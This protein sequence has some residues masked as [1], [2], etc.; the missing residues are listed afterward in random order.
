MLRLLFHGASAAVFCG[1]LWYDIH[2]IDLGAGTG[3]DVYG[4]KLRF[5]TFINLCV[6]ALFYV[7]CTLYDVAR[8]ARFSPKQLI[9]VRSLK[10]HLFTV[11]VFPVGAFVVLMFWGIYAVDRELIFPQFLDQ[12]FPAWANHVMHTVI[13]PVNLLEMALDYHTHPVP[14]WS[15]LKHLVGFSLAYQAWTLWVYFKT[16]S[17]IYPIFNALNG[18]QKV[19]FLQGATLMIILLYFVGEFLQQKVFKAKK[20]VMGDIRPPSPKKSTSPVNNSAKKPVAKDTVKKAAS[21]DGAKKSP[22]KNSVKKTA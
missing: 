17:W 2:Y 18:W 22:S 4:G 16:S 11:L 1:T 7:V 10:D 13:L 5:L 21:N 9:S 14:R 15:G 19:A 8:L 12:L 20:A 3:W 6:H